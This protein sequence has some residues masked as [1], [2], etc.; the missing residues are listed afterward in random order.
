MSGQTDCRT[1]TILTSVIFVDCVT[2]EKSLKQGGMVMHE[3]CLHVSS[4]Q[5]YLQLSIGRKRVLGVSR[6]YGTMGL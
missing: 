1:R 3:L 2:S 4:V 5:Y 6:G